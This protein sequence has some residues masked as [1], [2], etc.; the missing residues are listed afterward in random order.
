MNKPILTLALI[1]SCISIS[2]FAHN[3]LLSSDDFEI[4]KQDNYQGAALSSSMESE[5][6]WESFN[7]WQC[8]DV[9]NINYTCA[10]YDDVILV[11]SL[12]V[13]TEREIL[14]FDLH[15]E[16]RVDCNETLIKWRALIDGGKEVCIFAARMPD[17]QM[18]LESNL[19]QTLW[20]INRI[21][22]LNGYW[23]LDT[24]YQR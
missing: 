15:I 21:K 11:P 3:L 22:G 18:D 19:P 20:Y 8:F 24:P 10:S 9:A 7:Q 14:N 17:V 1:T 5:Q 16:D 4:E 23:S 6:H 12:M 2:V 13:E